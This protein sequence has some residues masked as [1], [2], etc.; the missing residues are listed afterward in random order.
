MGSLLYNMSE[1]SGG[2]TASV[3]P[4]ERRRA[5]MDWYEFCKEMRTAL[6]Q[7]GQVAKTS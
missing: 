4:S 5:L 1:G 7:C 3:E 2:V 6:Y